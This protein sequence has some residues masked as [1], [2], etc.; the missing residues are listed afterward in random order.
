M[1]KM[2]GRG[3]RDGCEIKLVVLGLSSTNRNRLQE[4]KPIIFLGEEVE[5]PGVEFI[6]FAGETEQSMARDL[7]E[8]IGPNTKTEIDPRVSDA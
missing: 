2:V 7:A 1:L 3:E 6:I 8:L 5:I 4:G